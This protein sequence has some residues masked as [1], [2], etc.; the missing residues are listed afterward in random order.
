MSSILV[1]I[2]LS[3]FHEMGSHYTGMFLATSLKLRNTKILLHYYIYSVTS[4]N[5]LMENVKN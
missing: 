3:L 1:L 2:I 4:E 5:R